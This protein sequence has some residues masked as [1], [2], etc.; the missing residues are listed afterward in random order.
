MDAIRVVIVL[1]FL[2]L[3][4]QVH[5]V[6][7]GFQVKSMKSR[8]ARKYALYDEAVHFFK[9]GKIVV[10][11]QFAR[12]CD[13]IKRGHEIREELRVRAGASDVLPVV[14]ARVAPNLLF[15]TISPSR[16]ASRLA[17]ALSS[18]ASRSQKIEL[19]P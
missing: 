6:P 15:F 11:I 12:Q 19:T 10:G 7:N 14:R 17:Q 5:G 4:R 8:Q 18:F 9:M 2:Q 13:P 16:H 3:A 1:V